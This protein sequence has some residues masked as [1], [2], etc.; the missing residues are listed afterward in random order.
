MSILFWTLFL[1]FFSVRIATKFAE[2]DLQVENL[3]PVIPCDLLP[4]T[5]WRNHDGSLWG[6][7]ANTI[8]WYNIT[9]QSWN[10]HLLPNA[11]TLNNL[12]IVCVI[13][14]SYI[15]LQEENTV[16]IYHVYEK[17]WL[18]VPISLH[19]TVVCHNDTLLLVDFE[20]DEIFEVNLFNGFQEKISQLE[21]STHHHMNQTQIS[22]I[23]WWTD[24]DKQTYIL[25]E[26][27]IWKTNGTVWYLLFEHSDPWPSLHSQSVAWTQN[28][29]LWI[30]TYEDFYDNLWIFNI[31]SKQWHQIE[32]QPR[33]NS[34]SP[35]ITWIEKGQ[36]CALIS[37]GE[38]KK[39]YQSTT[40]WCIQPKQERN[41]TSEI[42]STKE[43]LTIISDF[44]ESHSIIQVS[45]YP[46]FYP[47]YTN[48]SD[49]TKRSDI[50]N[51]AWHQE[52]STVFGSVIFFGTSLTIFGIV[53]I[54]WCIRTCVHFP[55]EALLLKDPP[56]IRYTAIP[57]TVA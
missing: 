49:G 50:S 42:N 18:E 47:T 14:D 48:V 17:Q 28:N 30:W 34:V 27:S 5:T 57:D 31:N 32:I 33:T 7:G 51:S 20:T 53:G 2:E 23:V 21:V 45:W 43:N 13:I 29:Q 39:S 8:M 12:K 40:T 4:S 1:C 41:H 19:Y 54:V 26:T 36:L 6:I 11:T 9:S 10:S 55:K 16:F 44:T 46:K 24:A 25:C 37:E 52:H 15:I 3:H 38:C 22:N 35:F 56:S